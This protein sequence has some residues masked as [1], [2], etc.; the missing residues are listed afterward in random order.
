MN[1]AQAGP[2]ELAVLR[3]WLRAAKG[4]LTFGS[5]AR[6][7]GKRGM[8]V[9]A[10]TLRRALDGRLPT[11]RTVMAFARGAGSDEDMARQVWAA[12]AA[13]VWAQPERPRFPRCRAG[14][15]PGPDR[16][17]PCDAYGR[18]RAVRACA[19]LWPRPRPRAC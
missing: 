13:A 2:V 8:A 15:P 14:S 6:R 3:G 5:L 17:G 7:A 4:K 11:E 9:S 12:A 10:C 19:G 18:R 1:R 16:S